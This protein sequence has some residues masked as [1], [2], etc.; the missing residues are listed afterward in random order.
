MKQPEDFWEHPKHFWEHPEDFG[1]SSVPPPCTERGVKCFLFFKAPFTP[2]GCTE[3]MLIR[4]HP[5]GPELKEVN[6]Y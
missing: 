5:H 3:G 1:L 4:T 2:P 6:C